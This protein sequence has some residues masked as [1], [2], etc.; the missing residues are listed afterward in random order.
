MDTNI[1]KLGAEGESVAPL[2]APEEFA[3]AEADA[4]EADD[5]YIHTF[6]KPFQYNGRMI[7]KLT[8]DF[9]RLTGRDCQAVENELRRIGTTLVAPTFSG[10]YLVRMAARACT[11]KIG[12][13]VFD[14][15][16]ARDYNRIRNKAQSFFLR[17]EL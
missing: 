16:S 5:V 12:A 3:A 6:H 11:E 8:F 2:I 4:R 1:K 15:M 9:D 14:L 17:S 10:E 7:E 13:D